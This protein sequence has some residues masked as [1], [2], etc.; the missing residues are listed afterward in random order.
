M[1][2]YVNQFPL[3]HVKGLVSVYTNESNKIA[4][5]VNLQSSGLL[6]VSSVNL[7]Q[8]KSN[9]ILFAHHI[10]TCTLKEG[11]KV[12]FFFLTSHQYSTFDS[13]DITIKE[14]TERGV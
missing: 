14:Y 3:P 1:R 9:E 2:C 10:R 13:E 5:S 7:L 11:E 8:V 6:P 4:P 12:N